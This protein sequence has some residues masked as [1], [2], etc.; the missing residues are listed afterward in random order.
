[1]CLGGG[2]GGGRGSGGWESC[3]AEQTKVPGGLWGRCVGMRGGGLTNTGF[4]E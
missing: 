1:M 4:D 3:R 2:G